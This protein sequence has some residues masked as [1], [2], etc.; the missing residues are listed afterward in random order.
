MYNQKWLHFENIFQFRRTYGL[1]P[2]I[3]FY[4]FTLLFFFQIKQTPSIFKPALTTN[5]FQF[6]VSLCCYLTILSNLLVSAANHVGQDFFQLDERYWIYIQFDPSFYKLQIKRDKSLVYSAN[7]FCC[8]KLC[9]KI[10]D[11]QISFNVQS[12]VNGVSR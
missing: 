3:H 12:A 10:I 11:Q 2:C 9:I 7:T 5:K 4:N 6:K 1:V 8:G